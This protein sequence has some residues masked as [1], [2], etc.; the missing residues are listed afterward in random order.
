MGCQR[1]HRG[2][3]GGYQV[4]TWD[5]C[6]RAS[7]RLLDLHGGS[8][9]RDPRSIVWATIIAEELGIEVPQRQEVIS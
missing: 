8:W 1:Q 5:S 3:V 9:P 7:N 6:L 2:Q 4:K